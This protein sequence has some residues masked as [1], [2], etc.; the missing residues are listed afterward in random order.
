METH[1]EGFE[2]SIAGKIFSFIMVGFIIILL[3]GIIFSSC[4]LEDDT[5][6][7]HQYVYSKGGGYSYD[8]VV[9]CSDPNVTGHKKMCISTHYF[10]SDWF[11]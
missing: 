6:Y 11:R 1:H 10:W 9:K 2:M 7:Y 8:K 4:E 3:I 5:C